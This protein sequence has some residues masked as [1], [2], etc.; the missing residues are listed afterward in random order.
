[1]TLLHALMWFG[2]CFSTLGDP[3]SPLA[4]EWIPGPPQGLVLGAVWLARIG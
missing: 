2:V 1:V 3:G 4:G